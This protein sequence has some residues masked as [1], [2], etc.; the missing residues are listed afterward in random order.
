MQR[1]RGNKNTE[2]EN[3]KTLNTKRKQKHRNKKGIKSKKG[4][5]IS[6]LTRNKPVEQDYTNENYAFKK[7]L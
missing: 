1:L 2:Y 5:S 4:V 3:K 6:K 7:L